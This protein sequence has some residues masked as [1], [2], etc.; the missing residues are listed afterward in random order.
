MRDVNYTILNIEVKTPRSNGRGQIWDHVAKVGNEMKLCL[1]SILSLGPSQPVVLQGVVIK[2]DTM[3]VYR[4]SLESE[5]VYVMRLF[6]QCA[7][8]S[9]SSGLF[10]LT[11]M[12]E[13]L[14]AVKDLAVTTIELIR[15]T[16]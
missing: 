2:E 8:C 7:I 16:A 6:A 4:L 11:R 10:P 9:R 15:D 12:L 5:G 14:Q 1:D 3:S 13:I